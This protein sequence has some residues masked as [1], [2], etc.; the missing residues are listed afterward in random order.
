MLERNS[1]IAYSHDKNLTITVLSV[2][3]RRARPS[4]RRI[5]AASGTIISL[6]RIQCPTTDYMINLL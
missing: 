2:G 6:C 5:F 3:Q 1:L 4:W